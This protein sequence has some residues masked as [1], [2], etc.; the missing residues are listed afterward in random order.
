MS[1][2]KFDLRKCLKWQ[3]MRAYE[4]I[5]RTD[6]NISILSEYANI[7][8]LAE[9]VNYILECGCMHSERKCKAALL[10]I[11]SGSGIK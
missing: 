9:S 8:N 5:S 6:K 10:Y 2:I 11:F 4:V 7:L 3:V 1:S